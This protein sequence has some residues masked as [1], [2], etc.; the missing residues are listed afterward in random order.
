D[1]ID[2]TDAAFDAVLFTS[3][4]DE[5]RP[6]A[7]RFPALSRHVRF[8]AYIPYGLEVGGGSVN[9]FHQYGQPVTLHASAVFV[10]S[11]SAREMYA[12]HCASG[13]GHVVV[14]GHPRMDAMSML[15][16]FAVDST[17]REQIGQR[18][19]VLWNAHFSFDADQWSTF[20][21]LAMPILEQFARRPDLAL[22]FRPHPLLWKKLVNL[23]VY[24]DNGVAA[25]RRELQAMGVVIDERTDHRHAFAASSALMTDAG[26]F[27][28]EY[29]VTGK[30]VLY[31]ANPH[32]L[33]LNEEGRAVSRHYDVAADASAIGAFLDSLGQRAPDEQTRRRA[34]IPAFFAGFDGGAGRRVLEHI[35]TRLAA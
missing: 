2:P 21:Q 29:F 32:G 25:L 15:D 19:A 26:S 20:D 12:R 6:A 9:L 17:L 27:L 13:A 3:P 16:E 8:T 1:G 33:G 23:G 18:K 7:Y 4:Y 31:L 28:M 10:R 22:L 30:P 5:T 14:S 24:D 35:K 11:G 34:A